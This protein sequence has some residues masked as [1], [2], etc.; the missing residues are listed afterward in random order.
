MRDAGATYQQ[1]ADVFSISRT[2][3]WAWL[4]PAFKQRRREYLNSRKTHIANRCSLYNSR[5]AKRI[6]KQ[7]A[8][9]Y[10]NNKEE[11]RA[12]MRIYY[13]GHK[14]EAYVKS[15]TRYALKQGAVIGATAMQLTEIKEIYRHASEDPKVRCYLCGKLIPKGRRHVDHIMP[16]SKGGLHRPSNLAVACDTCNLSKYDKLPNEIG[17]LI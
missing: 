6:K 16:L 3:A 9:Y 11:M 8:C 12:K 2:T 1:I 5:H 10:M 13:L 14:D 4:T 7:K 17:I 15:A